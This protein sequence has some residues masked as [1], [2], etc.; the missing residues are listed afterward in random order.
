[1]DSDDEADQTKAD[2]EESNA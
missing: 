2:Q 1:M